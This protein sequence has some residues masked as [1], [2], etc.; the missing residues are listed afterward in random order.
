RQ[1]HFARGRRLL[2]AGVNVALATN[3]NPGS[4][5]SESIALA[6]GLAC[7]GNGLTPAEAYWAATR[8][9]ALA[10]R[11]FDLGRLMFGGAAD[12]VVFGCSSYRHLPYHLGINHVRWVLKGGRV[13]VSSDPQPLCDSD[14]GLD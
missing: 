13:V 3:L 4:A 6:C 7:L 2:A 12:V 10:L 5:M 1:P 8:G 14:A 9:A 11:R